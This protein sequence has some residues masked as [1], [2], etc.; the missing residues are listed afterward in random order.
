VSTLYQPSPILQFQRLFVRLSTLKHRREW[1]AD[2]VLAT[3]TVSANADC[4]NGAILHSSA[5]F[6]RRDEPKTRR[7]D[8]AQGSRRLAS[9]LSD[10]TNP[11]ARPHMLWPWLGSHR[12]VE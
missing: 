7:V 5:R 1:L 10:R 12:G 11:Y 9:A 2:T 3:A 6:R 4:D 8:T